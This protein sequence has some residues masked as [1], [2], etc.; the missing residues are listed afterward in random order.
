MVP[1]LLN[2]SDPAAVFAQ[3]VSWESRSG[4][5][6]RVARVGSVRTFCG[7]EALVSIVLPLSF[8]RASSRGLLVFAMVF[9][10]CLEFCLIFRA[11]ERPRD[12]GIGWWVP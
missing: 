9:H 5:R 11:L 3:A 2:R 1:K 6:Y 7:C 8:S 12:S 10:N 4:V